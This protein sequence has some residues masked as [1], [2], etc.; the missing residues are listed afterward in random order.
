MGGAKSCLDLSGLSCVTWEV[1]FKP[2]LKRVFFSIFWPIRATS[3]IYFCFALI[4]FVGP[5]LGMAPPGREGEGGGGG[6]APGEGAQGAENGP[7]RPAGGGE[8]K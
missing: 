7:G 3:H 1:A 4:F 6:G 8:P 2:A 5:P